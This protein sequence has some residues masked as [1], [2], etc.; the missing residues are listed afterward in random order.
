M[1]TR[2][3]NRRARNH[4]PLKKHL[5]PPSLSLGGTPRT[6]LPRSSWMQAPSSAAPSLLGD[7]AG[8]TASAAPKAG[9]GEAGG[10]P[11]RG[12]E[13]H[14]TG[15]NRAGVPAGVPASNSAAS[16][17]RGGS[18]ALHMA[19]AQR[20]QGKASVPGGAEA[21]GSL[22]TSGL[23]SLCF[24]LSSLIPLKLGQGSSSERP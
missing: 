7:R 16:S 11:P 3:N 15:A 6:G 18:A 2:S 5:G 14:T 20:P 13:L 1:F 24:W 22:F 23:P 8:K 19:C 21:L 10:T 9:P 12:C 4:P 17:C